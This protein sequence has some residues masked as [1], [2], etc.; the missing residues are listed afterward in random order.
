MPAHADRLFARSRQMLPAIALPAWEA[1][2]RSLVMIVIIIA[3]TML[4]A[5]AM[6][7]NTEEKAQVLLSRGQVGEAIALYERKR[8]SAWLDPFE[9]YSLAN[10]YAAKGRDRDLVALLEAEIARRPAS[11]WARTLLTTH[12]R[13]QGD[14]G[15]EARI[16]FQSFAR[17]P[18]Q[19]DFRRLIALYRLLG[20]RDGERATLT[21]ARA[22]NLTQPSDL[23]R[24]DTLN[25][26]M[27]STVP[28][29]VWR[30]AA[31][32]VQSEPQQ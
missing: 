1:P 3:I 25:S 17:T 6:L 8:D 28:S 7:P 27:A 4:A 16:L 30:S 10:L 14:M 5:I 31:A 9:T 15:D 13:E 22:E 18:T 2:E 12:Y 26:P 32:F 19:A 11:D 20:D 24:L 21:L 29:A 23:E